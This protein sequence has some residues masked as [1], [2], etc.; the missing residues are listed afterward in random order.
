MPNDLDQVASDASEHVKIAGVRIA[1]EHVLH[2]QRQPV[3]AFAHVGPADRRPNPHP[4]GNRD[5]RQQLCVWG[6]IRCLWIAFALTIT[7]A[8][9]AFAGLDDVPA[10][11]PGSF[12]V[13]TK[14][15][16]WIVTTTC[17]TY[18]LM[19]LPHR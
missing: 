14:C 5:H 11:I 18:Q 10:V 16:G 3:H 19:R 1:V 17:R 15:R 2:L 9:S 13:L 8:S 12:V 6:S 7:V 4:A